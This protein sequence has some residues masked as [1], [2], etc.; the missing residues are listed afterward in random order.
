MRS[1]PQPVIKPPPNPAL[2]RSGW[3]RPILVCRCSKKALPLYQCDIIQPPAERQPVGRA[4][5]AR[6]FR[7]KRLIRY[8]ESCRSDHLTHACGIMPQ[9]RESCRADSPVRSRGVHAWGAGTHAAAQGCFTPT[10][11][12]VGCWRSCV[13]CWRSCRRC[14]GSCLDGRPIHA[15]GIMP[16]VLVIMPRRG[17]AANARS[18]PGGL[19]RMPR[20]RVWGALAAACPAQPAVPADRPCRCAQDRWFFADQLYRSIRVALAGAAS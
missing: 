11:S 17:A 9:M 5:P 8:W 13:G 16:V 15:R 12:C 20:H 7:E 14:A 2:Q 1:S 3:I 6:G 18:M 4:G 10:G 19:A